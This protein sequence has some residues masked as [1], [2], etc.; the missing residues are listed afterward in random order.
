MKKSLYSVLFS[1]DDFITYKVL[2]TGTY[3]RSLNY[4]NKHCHLP[5]KFYRVELTEL[6]G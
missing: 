6:R 3:N 2:Y 5:L 4:L 1:D